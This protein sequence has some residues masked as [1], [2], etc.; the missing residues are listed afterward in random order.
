M[1]VI[2][3]TKGV[4]ASDSRATEGYKIFSDRVKKLFKLAN[5]GMVG[6]A[7]DCDCR[8]VIELLGRATPKKMPSKHELCDTKTVFRGIVVFPKGEV[9]EVLIDERDD[10]SED[11]WYAAVVEIS[12]KYHAVGCGEDDALVAMRM[13]ATAMQAV[14]TA[15]A[16]NAGCGGA[17]QTMKLEDLKAPRKRATGGAGAAKKRGGRA[18]K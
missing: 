16:G 15:I 9:F 4:L 3:Y 12:E 11:R 18:K 6:T 14:K 13:G 10:V 17:V 1:T 5:G 7:G 2:A 8:D